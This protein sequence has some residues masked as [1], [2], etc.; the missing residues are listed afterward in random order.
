M[1]GP[2]LS[3]EALPADISYGGPREFVSHVYCLGY[4]DNYAMSKECGHNPGTQQ[5]WK[6]LAACSKGMKYANSKNFQIDILGTKKENMTNRVRN[7]LEILFDLKAKGI[8]LIDSLIMGWY[9]TQKQQYT[10]SKKLC[11]KLPSK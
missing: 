5:F 7:K 1:K 10:K 9:I 3:K 8:W 4:G 11:C 2:K 6:L